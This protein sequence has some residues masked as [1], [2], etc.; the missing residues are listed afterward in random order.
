[1]RS[2]HGIRASEGR[3]RAVAETLATGATVQVNYGESD[4]SA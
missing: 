2:A 1:M 3:E 4:L